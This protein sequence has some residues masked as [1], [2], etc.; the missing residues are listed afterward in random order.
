MDEHIVFNLPNKEARKDI[1]SYY[2]A[3]IPFHVDADVA[4]IA[5]KTNGFS[6]ADLNNLVLMTAWK[7]LSQ[8]RDTLTTQDFYLP[9]H[10]IYYQ[11]IRRVSNNVNRHSV[12]VHEAGAPNRREIVSGH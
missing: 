1:L 10:D 8:N 9:I 6:G 5:G 12:A 2:L 7:A 11:D 3:D 4:A